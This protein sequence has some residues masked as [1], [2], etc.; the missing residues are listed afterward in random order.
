MVDLK[1]STTTSHPQHTK[2]TA[3][4]GDVALGGNDSGV[5][6][7]GQLKTARR[8][9]L[10]GDLKSILQQV[11]TLGE[12][13]LDSPTE[14]RLQR[15]KDGIRQFLERVGKELFSLRNELGPSKDGQQKVYQ[16]IETVDH[17]LD[18]LTRETLQQDKALLLLGSLDD[19]RGLAL[20]IIR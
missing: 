4:Q 3:K 7:S 1:V 14:G 12:R 20:D 18:G 13:F 15:Y 11:R 5:S 17:E 8:E 9:T 2:T 10:D 6:F 19:I 16:L